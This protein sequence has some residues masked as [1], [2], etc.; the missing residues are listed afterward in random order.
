[1]TILP[2]PKRQVAACTH[3]WDEANN[4]DI[5]AGVVIACTLDERQF[6]INK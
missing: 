1:L 2:P 4:F 6:F 3:A 5:E